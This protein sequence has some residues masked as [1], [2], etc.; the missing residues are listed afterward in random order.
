MLVGAFACHG[1]LLAAVGVYGLISYSVA[2][3]TREIGIRVALGARPAQV[4][5]PVVREGMTLASI[6]VALGLA[7]ALAATKLLSS[8]L[9]GGGPHRSPDLHRGRVAPAVGRVPGELH[10]V[11]PRPARRP[12]H[13]AR[14][15]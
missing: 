13:R 7:G 8:Y 6:G 5:G 10:P 3:R 2:Q 15:E 4:I 11:P 12:A 9:F 14:A 1:V